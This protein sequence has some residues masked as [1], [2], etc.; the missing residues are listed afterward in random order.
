MTLEEIKE[1]LAA[2]FISRKAFKERLGIPPKVATK[3]FSELSTLLVE[4]LRREHQDTSLYDSIR[5][6]YLPTIF[7]VKN[8]TELK[9][10]IEKGDSK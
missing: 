9:R 2:P 10:Y 1:Q 6:S 8:V 3:L 7:V 5:N 4:E